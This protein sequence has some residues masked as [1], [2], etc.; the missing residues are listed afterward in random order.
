MED[1]R[2]EAPACAAGRAGG[3]CGDSRSHAR[4]GDGGARVVDARAQEFARRV[5]YGTLH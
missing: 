3:L 1:F 4:Q 5:R 2:L